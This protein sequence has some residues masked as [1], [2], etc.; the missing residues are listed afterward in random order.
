MLACGGKLVT[1]QNQDFTFWT[2]ED[3]NLVYAITDGTSASV[4]V[5]AFTAEWRLSDEPGGAS[6][7][8]YASGGSGIVLSGCTAT[9]SLAASDTAGCN[10][11]GTYWAELS[12]S[13]G[14]GYTDILATGWAIINRRSL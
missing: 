12:A 10:I 7:L 13:D 9:V 6:L 5:G 11:N 2:G 4:D 8:R 1:K 3:K 14:E